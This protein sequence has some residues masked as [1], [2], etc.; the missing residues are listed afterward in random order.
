MIWGW[1][2]MSQIACTLTTSLDNTFSGNRSFM[3]R[4]PCLRMRTAG[5]ACRRHRQEHPQVLDIRRLQAQY[6][7]N[8]RATRA[9]TYMGH[10]H[11]LLVPWH[12]GLIGQ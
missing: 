1:Q 7:V 8:T 11:D 2:V 5:L 12:G 9:T 6:V 4:L 3:D 10:L